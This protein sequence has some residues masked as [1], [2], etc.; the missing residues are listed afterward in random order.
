[1]F[2]SEEAF[3]GGGQLFMLEQTRACDLGLASSPGVSVNGNELG[4]LLPLGWGTSSNMGAML[5]AYSWSPCTLFPASIRKVL[6]CSLRSQCK[7]S[8]RRVHRLKEKACC[9]HRYDP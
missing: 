5:A 7:S 6:G 4:M 8:G 9:M 3:A 2:V 1:M